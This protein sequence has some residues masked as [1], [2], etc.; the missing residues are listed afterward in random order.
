M[1]QARTPFLVAILLTAL[2]AHAPKVH[3]LPATGF[4]ASRLAA[5]RFPRTGPLP[6]GVYQIFWNPNRYPDQLA[7]VATR[8]GADPHFVTFFRDLGRP[9]PVEPLQAILSR[10][11]LPVISLELHRWR[12]RDAGDVARIA[13][14]AFDE[15]FR[16]YARD[17]RAFRYPVLLRFGFEMNG[18]WFPWGGQPESF[19]AAWQHVHDMFHEEKATNV[20]WVWSPNAVSGPDTPRNGFEHYWPG[21]AYVDV[22]GLDGYNFGDHHDEWHTWEEAEEVFGPAL[23]KIEASGVPHPILITE[24][25][26]TDDGDA[27]RRA[28]WI[29]RAHAYFAGRPAIIGAIWFNHDKR[30]EGEKNWRIDADPL[31]LEAWRECFIRGSAPRSDG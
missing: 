29:R 1:R 16:A 6:W 4:P 12:T 25:G 22:I 3:A 13:E 24:F 30:R 18:D 5:L 7:D 11:A 19:K 10:G 14:G 2:L 31:S 21:D 27:K 28:E 23:A 8:L 20:L 26:C 9:F 17:A 15:F